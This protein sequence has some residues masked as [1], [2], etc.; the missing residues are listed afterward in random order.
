MSIFLILNV[1]ANHNSKLDSSLLNTV[2]ECF[3][4]LSV[5][6]TRILDLKFFHINNN[7]NIIIIFNSF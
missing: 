2:K 1:V 4:V 6:G 7:N 5:S 3:G